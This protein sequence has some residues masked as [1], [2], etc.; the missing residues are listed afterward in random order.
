[1]SWGG[2]HIELPS[3][4]KIVDVQRRGTIL[5]AQH[6]NLMEAEP[7]QSI[8]KE[9]R[10]IR[11]RLQQHTFDAFRTFVIANMHLEVADEQKQ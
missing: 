1:M 3:E 6:N 5:V 11:P 2:Q 8:N 4:H 9:T 10:I 7:P